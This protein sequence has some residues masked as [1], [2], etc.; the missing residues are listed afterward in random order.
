MVSDAVVTLCMRVSSHMYDQ[1]E[2]SDISK[3][4]LFWPVLLHD[5]QLVSETAMSF[6]QALYIDRQF[7]SD[8]AANFCQAV[9]LH[10]SIACE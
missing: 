8:I 2:V 9:T 4:I 6:C 10:W 5:K 1:Q 3:V 7:V